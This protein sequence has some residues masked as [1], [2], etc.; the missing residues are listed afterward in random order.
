M[1]IRKLADL[2]LEIQASIIGHTYMLNKYFLEVTVEESDEY[3]SKMT[4]GFLLFFLYDLDELM[5]L[6][7]DFKDSIRTSEFYLIV[8]DN[9]E[10]DHHRECM[11]ATWLIE[12]SACRMRCPETDELVKNAAELLGFHSYD[13]P[14]SYSR[15][16]QIEV[17]E[18]TE[19][20]KESK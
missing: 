15:W 20:K 19:D 4:N 17:S 1:T 14:K 10:C 18:V 11:I 7:N 12:F 6:H 16:A 5:P 2:P 8:N 3:F 13:I 9:S